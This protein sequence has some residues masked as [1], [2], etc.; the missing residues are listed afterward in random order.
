MFR[1]ELPL[2]GVGRV[3]ERD[4]A[5][6][7]PVAGGLRET[8]ELL[9]DRVGERGGHVA[10]RRERAAALEQGRH[11]RDGHRDVVLDALA[12]VPL[13]LRDGLA[14]PPQ[15]LGLRLALDKQLG[16]SSDR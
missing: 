12:R 14:Q 4:H 16:K 15:R 13:R 5:E 6:P 11:P 3:A 9:D 2:P 10:Q 1:K 8:D 7:E